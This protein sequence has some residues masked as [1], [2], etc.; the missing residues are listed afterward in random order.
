MSI[1]IDKMRYL[2]YIINVMNKSVVIMPKTKKILE[3]MGQNI[4][5][6]RLRRDLSVNLVCERE[7]ISITS[8]WLVEKGSPR[9]AIGI[10]AAV[11]MALNGLDEDLLKVASDD[12]LGHTL[13]D[14]RITPKKRASKK[15]K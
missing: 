4:R 2:L 5:M 11:L 7:S 9:I 13:Q 10:Y 8:L 3:E 12:K 1:I 14:L 15:E 6:A